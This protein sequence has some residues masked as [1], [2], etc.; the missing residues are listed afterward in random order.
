MTGTRVPFTSICQSGTVMIN[1]NIALSSL[2]SLGDLNQQ[3]MPIGR[4]YKAGHLPT[5]VSHPPQLV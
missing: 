4:T 2:G 5:A 3:V 1:V